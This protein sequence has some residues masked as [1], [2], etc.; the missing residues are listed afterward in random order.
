MYVEKIQLTLE[1]CMLQASSPH[2]P[3]HRSKIHKSLLTPPKLNY[4]PSASLGMGSRTPSDQSAD[5]QT[6]LED[7]VEQCIQ[8][9]PHIQTTITDQKYCLWLVE[10]VDAKPTQKAYC[11]YTEKNLHRSGLTQFQPVLFKRQ[12]QSGGTCTTSKLAY[13]WVL[14][15]LEIAVVH[16]FKST[17]NFCLKKLGTIFERQ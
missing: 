12:R 15:S 2:P 17:I 13:L 6:L 7:G 8:L 9:A 10:S 4:S 14:F 1:Q 16:I 11:I 5:A 3:T